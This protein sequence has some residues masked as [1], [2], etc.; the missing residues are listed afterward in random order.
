SDLSSILLTMSLLDYV[1]E[2]AS[3]KK[4]ESQNT[5]QIIERSTKNLRDNQVKIPAKKKIRFVHLADV[6]LGAFKAQHEALRDA[7]A[8]LLKMVVEFC[9]EY[10]VDF[11]LIAGDLFHGNVVKIEVQKEAASILTDADEHGIRVYVVYGSHDASPTHSSSVDVLA[12]A[13]R[14]T[15]VERMEYG[16]NEKIQLQPVIDKTGV[17]IVG[18]HGRK[19]EIEAAYLAALDFE[20]LEKIPKPR[21]FLLHS[22]VAEYRPDFLREDEG[23]PLSLI[24]KNFDY[25]AC[26]HV[27]RRSVNLVKG[28]GPIVYPGAL[29]GSSTKDLEEN[30]ERLPGIYLLDFD[31]K[32][33]EENLTFVDVYSLAELTGHPGEIPDIMFAQFSFGTTTPGEVEE[34]LKNWIEKKELSNT[35]VYLK[36]EGK[37]SEGK[38]SQIPF[39]AIAKAGIERGA[40]DVLVNREGLREPIDEI[41]HVV[42][43]ESVAEIEWKV[44]EE[45]FQDKE[46]ARQALKFLHILGAEKLEGESDKDY[47]GRIKSEVWKELGLGGE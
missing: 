38:R 1:R 31:D 21:I 5:N 18:V 27:H 17:A 45:V 34:Q 3:E 33:G 9:K 42:H 8:K 15:S 35:I 14:I 29:F 7:P 43:G 40:I 10:D 28:Y 12:A 30:T 25:Y 6:H 36:V 46:A 22:A 20:A 19:R 24:P 32:I 11:I 23:V 41:E 2:E 37:L 47:F 13:K 39:E 16:E 26:G 44:A 4:T